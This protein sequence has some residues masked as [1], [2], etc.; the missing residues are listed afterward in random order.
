MH[1]LRYSFD[2]SQAFFDNDSPQWKTKFLLAKKCHKLV[3][4]KE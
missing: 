2:V 3:V 1:N 4:N